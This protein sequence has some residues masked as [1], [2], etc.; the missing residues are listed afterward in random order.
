MVTGRMVPYERPQIVDE[1]VDE[2]QGIGAIIIKSQIDHDAGFGKQYRWEGYVVDKN[3]NIKS[4]WSDNAYELELRKGK[5]IEMKAV[6]LLKL[7]EKK[8]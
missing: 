5:R 6:E 2:E 4:V 7:M 8:K 3:G 1:Y